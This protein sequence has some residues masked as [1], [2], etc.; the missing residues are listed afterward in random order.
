MGD[1]TV[2]NVP[3]DHRGNTEGQKHR[4]GTKPDSRGERRKADLLVAC[5]CCSVFPR[6]SFESELLSLE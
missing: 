6:L 2:M 4:I 1:K 5:F 3:A